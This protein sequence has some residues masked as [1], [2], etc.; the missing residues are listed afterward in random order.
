MAAKLTKKDLIRVIAENQDR[1]QEDVSATLEAILEQITQAAKSGQE[2]SL[3][4]FGSFTRKDRPAR[5]GRNPKTGE[6][7]QIAA[8]SGLSFKAHKAVKDLLNA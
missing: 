2:V 7:L 8:S 3:H 6:S 4:G 1:T 5:P